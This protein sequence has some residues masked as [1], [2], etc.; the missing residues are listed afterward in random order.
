LKHDLYS[1]DAD[2]NSVF[3][4][5]GTYEVKGDSIIFHSEFNFDSS[6]NFG[7]PSEE[8]QV[9]VVRDDGKMILV[10]DAERYDDE[11]RMKAN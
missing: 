3:K 9:Y 4:N 6:K 5:Y 11:W 2:C 8:K 1:E 7:L 10:Y